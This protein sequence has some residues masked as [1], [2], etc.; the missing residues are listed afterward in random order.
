MTT[1]SATAGVRTV[2]EVLADLAAAAV[3][4][5]EAER[6]RDELARLAA[7]SGASWV[8]IA[9]QLGVTRQAARQ[10]YGL[11]GAG[12]AAAVLDLTDRG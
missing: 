5:R 7:A 8:A 2:P 3:Q 11:G 6:R 4:V 1:A 10:R 9:Q 12:D